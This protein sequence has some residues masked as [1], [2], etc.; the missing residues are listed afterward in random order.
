MFLICD[1]VQTEMFLQNKHLPIKVEK[2]NKN[3]Q[4]M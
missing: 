3:M 2:G 1:S 4:E